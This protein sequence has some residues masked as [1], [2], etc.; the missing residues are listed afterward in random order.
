[1]M[2]ATERGFCILLI[3]STL[4]INHKSE[5]KGSYDGRREGGYVRS[6]D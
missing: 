2:V 3:C 1:M 5:G 6:K 4:Q